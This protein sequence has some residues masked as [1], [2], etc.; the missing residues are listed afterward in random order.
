MVAAC[1]TLLWAGAALAKPTPG[2]ICAAAKQT[3][4]GHKAKSKLTCYAKYTHSG[5]SFDLAA[6]LKKAETAF[7]KAFQRAEFTKK[8]KSRGCAT[9]GDAAAVEAL[10]DDFVAAVVEALPA[11][12]PT[13]TPTPIPPQSCTVNSDCPS[14]NCYKGTCVPICA[15][16]IQDGNETG[17]DCGGSCP[18]S[19][20]L[21]PCTQDAQCASG[22]CNAG[23][24]DCSPGYANCDGNSAN[25]CE[26]FLAG[27]P[28]NCLACG[29]VCN[30]TNGQPACAPGVG[31]YI[32]GCFPGYADCNMDGGD[33]CEVSTTT[34]PANCGNCFQACSVGQACT[35]G[36]CG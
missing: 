13:P 17:I 22:T 28:G 11:A 25:G 9:S 14:N 35:N 15:D 18:L 26:V 34:D 36:V 6:C 4:V 3:A 32:A 33:G 7:A 20:L 31:C 2:E 1:A 5:G 24:C 23:E 8:G 12:L 10:V 19:C 29:N 16:G 21:S 30:S 27:D